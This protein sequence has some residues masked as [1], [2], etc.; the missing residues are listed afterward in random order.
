MVYIVLI[1]IIVVLALLLR[2]KLLIDKEHEL[3]VKLKEQQKVSA[4]S[5]KNYE[6]A[7]YVFRDIANNYNSSSNE[8]EKL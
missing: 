2:R 7:K 1:T 3:E 4:E 8:Y 6:K 5:E